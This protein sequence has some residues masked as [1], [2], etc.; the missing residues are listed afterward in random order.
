M[1]RRG[2]LGMLAAVPVAA[3]ASAEGIGW[4]EDEAVRVQLPRY[5]GTIQSLEPEVFAGS[6]QIGESLRRHGSPMTRVLAHPRQ[7]ELYRLDAE[8]GD[9]A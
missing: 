3:K 2:F 1:D 8:G 9:E 7:V 4:L 6:F 5:V